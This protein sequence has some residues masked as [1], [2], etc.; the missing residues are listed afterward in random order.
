MKGVAETFLSEERAREDPDT[1]D[2]CEKETRELVNG[3]FGGEQ[4]VCRVVPDEV[5]AFTIADGNLIQ[6]NFLE[7]LVNE[8]NV[9]FQREG[10]ELRN[11]T[12]KYTERQIKKDDKL[13]P[14]DNT[15]G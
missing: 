2:E 12:A 5:S 4:D 14:A 9:R 6:S 10:A 3:A 11:R 1:V 15:V 13:R 8:I 7:A